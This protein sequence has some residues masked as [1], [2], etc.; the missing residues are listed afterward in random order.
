MFEKKAHGTSTLLGEYYIHCYSISIFKANWMAF[1]HFVA[2]T[3]VSLHR[4][5]AHIQMYRDIAP[6]RTT[7]L[8]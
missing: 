6:I 8:F 7:I 1:E 5:L 3:Y 2:L 4:K